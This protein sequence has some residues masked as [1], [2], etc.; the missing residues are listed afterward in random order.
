[1]EQDTSWEPPSEATAI[2]RR[3][4]DA[5]LRWSISQPGSAA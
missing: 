5:T 4:L 3:V 1:V 2:G